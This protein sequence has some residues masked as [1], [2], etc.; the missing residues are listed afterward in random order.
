M[1]KTFEIKTIGTIHSKNHNYYI[2][3]D[4]KYRAALTNIQGFS[5]LQIIWW[6]SYF[7]KDEY[8]SIIVTDKPYKKGPDKLGIFATRSN[9]RPNPVLITNIYVQKI[10]PEKG[11]IYTPYIDAEEGTPLIDIKPYHLSERVK[12]C[13]VPGWCSHWPEWHEDAGDF[14]WQAE[15]NF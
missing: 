4:E 12:N 1:N 14:D 8:R 11:I 6:G 15:F 5:H 13:S 9:I 2:Q 3:V 10:D 7:D